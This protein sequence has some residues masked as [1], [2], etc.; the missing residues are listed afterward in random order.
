MRRVVC[1]LSFATLVVGLVQGIPPKDANNHKN[2]PLPH[3]SNYP[4][5]AYSQH[6]LYTAALQLLQTYAAQLQQGQ[7][8]SQP[9]TY[10]QQ[11]LPAPQQYL[12]A[13]QQYLPAQQYL[14][15][16]S[17]YPSLPMQ[18]P[19]NSGRYPIPVAGW[20][21]PRND[22]RDDRMIFV[23]AFGG[24]GGGGGKDNQGLLPNVPTPRPVPIPPI[25]PV[26]TPTSPGIIL[27]TPT[28]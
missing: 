28:S 20:H 5:S 23:K 25:V 6:D 12:P 3:G 10:P 1:S 7:L 26:P 8:G 24:G 11:Y 15:T 19:T 13:P 2:D 9:H 16:P 27:P 21:Q 17:Y 22:D 18:Y 4:T 14:P